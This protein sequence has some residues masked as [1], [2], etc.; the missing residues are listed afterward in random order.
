MIALCSSNL[1]CYNAILLTT[2]EGLEELTCKSKGLMETAHT[3]GHIPRL[4]I[5][6][7]HT[8]KM[9]HHH[10]A[11]GL[12][13]YCNRGRRSWPD[14]T[15]ASPHRPPPHVPRTHQT[16]WMRCRGDITAAADGWP[17]KVQL[18]QEG[19]WG[20]RGG[21]GAAVWE[22]IEQAVR[23]GRWAHLGSR[24]VGPGAKARRRRW[25]A[26]VRRRRRIAI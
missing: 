13:H 3:H 17:S 19:K 16:Q 25:H 22:S 9:W 11:V 18:A 2:W 21:G 20:G 26:R 1:N 12:L 8:L 5:R 10:D 23:L 6:H 15:T 14:E 24:A 7:R 4:Q